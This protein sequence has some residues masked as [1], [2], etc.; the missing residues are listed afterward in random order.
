M[1]ASGQRLA[2]LCDFI[3]KIRVSGV[4][5]SM[6]AERGGCSE[7]G[8]ITDKGIYLLALGRRSSVTLWLLKN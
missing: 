4:V 1:L 8:W 5:G 7:R 3:G 2:A 6:W